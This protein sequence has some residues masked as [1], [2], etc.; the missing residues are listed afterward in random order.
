MLN[1]R[2]APLVLALASAVILGSALASQ[3]VGGL[4]PCELCIWQRWP[5]VATIVLGLAAAA[6]RR[7]ARRALL[8]LAGLVFLAGAAVAAFHVGVE[9]HWWQGLQSCGGNL[10]QARTVEELRAALL[11][12]PVVRCDEI[13]WSL[14]G[15][16]MAGWN[17]LLSLG[18]AALSFASALSK[19]TGGR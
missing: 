9:Q 2:L 12:Q 14:F 10:P 19:P 1:G 4:S 6:V 8:A 18:L 15:I 3:Y 11:Q 17:F 7:A 13:A 5:Y 16:S